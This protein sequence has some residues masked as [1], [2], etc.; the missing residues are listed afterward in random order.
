VFLGVLVA[1][2]TQT[3]AARA[4]PELFFGFA[5]DGPKFEPAQSYA[6]ASGLGASA[7][8]ITL[9]WQAGQSDLSSSQIAE[10]DR[11]V[12]GAGAARLVVA[13]Y[14]DSNLEAPQDDAA[15]DQYCTFARNVIARYPAINDVVV[16]NEPNKQL[17]WKPQFDAAGVSVA[18]AAYAALLARCWDV[19]HAF[20]PT[21]NVLAPA[22]SPRG[23]DNP[24]AV[25][26]VSHSPASFIRK[27]GEAY[28]ASGRQQPIFDTVAHHPY[29][30]SPSERPWKKH[31][32]GVI[33]MGDW[34]K[35]MQLLAEAFAGTAQPIPGECSGGRCTSIWYTEAGHQT[36]VD[37][38]K[39]DLYIGIENY[40]DPVPDYA[41]SEP[42]APP[43]SPDSKAP[44]QWTQ[45]LDS[46]RLAFCQPYV[47]AYFNFQLWDDRNLRSWQAAPLWVDRTPKDSYPAFVQAIAEVNARSVD[48]TA[49][50]GGQTWTAPGL[51]Q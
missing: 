44:D 18:P 35:L 46:V 30:L 40:A 39:R 34:D 27:L 41:G 15:R 51:P 1:A 20:R 14:S 8:R 48:C 25:N 23:T 19:L 29:G 2:V 12:G 45:T 6:L 4:G 31:E 5:A 47:D 43:P 28:R 10:L 26:N 13:I 24:A 42:S 33:A 7:F 36:A 9:R 21:V 32:G 49:L 38:A 37:D 11:A 17:F 16:W 22:T 3:P 50:K